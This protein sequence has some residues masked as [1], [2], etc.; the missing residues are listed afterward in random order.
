MSAGDAVTR[1]CVLYVDMWM[2]FISCPH[3]AA[4]PGVCRHGMH[5]NTLSCIFVYFTNAWQRSIP[6][7]SFSV[8]MTFE[9]GE[10]GQ[11]K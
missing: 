1:D 4:A 3:V 8:P 7:T 11:Y 10:Q 9:D 2:H 6:I 5:V